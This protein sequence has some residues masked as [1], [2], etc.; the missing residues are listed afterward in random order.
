MEKYKT[1]YLKLFN[2]LSDKI[3]DLKKLQQEL[4]EEY[5]RLSENDADE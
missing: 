1:L 5:I 2:S 4:E 3:E